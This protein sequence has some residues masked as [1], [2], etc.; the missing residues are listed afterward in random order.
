[1]DFGAA[2]RTLTLG[3]QNTFPLHFF[4]AR[5]DHLPAVGVEIIDTGFDMSELPMLAACYD[6]ARRSLS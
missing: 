2:D 3:G 4:E 6:G 1:M 5:P